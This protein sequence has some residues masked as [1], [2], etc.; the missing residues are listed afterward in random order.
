MSEDETRIILVRDLL[1]DMQRK[2]DIA[3][4]ALKCV[5]SSPDFAPTDGDELMN[6]K[7]EAEMALEKIN[8]A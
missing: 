3:V 1:Q 5:V 7:H 8:E 4:D 6:I 2:L